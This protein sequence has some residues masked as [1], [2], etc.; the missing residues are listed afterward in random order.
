MRILISY[1]F[2]GARANYYAGIEH[3]ARSLPSLCSKLRASISLAVVTDHNS[4]ASLPLALR[5]HQS[6]KLFDICD[7]ISTSSMNPRLW[8]YAILSLADLADY[9]AIL[10]RDSDSTI[11]DCEA[12]AINEWLLS[13]FSF[14]IIRGS[15]IHL[16]P[17][18]AGLFS[19]RRSGYSLLSS[20]ISS[21]LFGWL[22]SLP[23]YRTDQLCL[24]LLV[25]PGVLRS[26][27]IHTV[28]WRYRYETFR[29]LDIKDAIFP[30]Q[31]IIP[32]EEIKVFPLSSPPFVSSPEESFGA[33]PL[34]LS[35]LLQCSPILFFFWYHFHR[36]LGDINLRVS[37]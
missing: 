36:F 8:R 4:L 34:Y 16:W 12:F 14:S 13:G 19:V 18:M 29:K 20:L 33:P 22:A 24:G 25:Y 17:I 23:G 37:P 5:D 35:L 1:C 27:L 30:G 7:C 3:V 28:Y 15:R 31:Y 2:F 21:R 26:S 9:D 11:G 10:F 6:I 32:Q